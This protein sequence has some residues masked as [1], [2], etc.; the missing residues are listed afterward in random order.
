MTSNRRMVNRTSWV[1]MKMIVAA[2]AVWLGASSVAICQLSDNFTP[3]GR[4][5]TSQHCGCG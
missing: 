4:E 3:R 2:V 5:G 1:L